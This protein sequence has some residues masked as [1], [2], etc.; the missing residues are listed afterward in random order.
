MV[1][2]V[3]GG[4]GFL[5]R[6]L[7]RRLA[8]EDII[9]RAYGRRL[10][11]S[12]GKVEFIYGELLDRSRLRGAL[13]GVDCVFHLA[14]STLPQTSNEDPQADVQG[15]VIA[16]I[17]LLEACVEA[18]VQTVVFPSSGGTVYGPAM[19]GLDLTE[20]HPTNPISSYGITKLAVEK[21]LALYRHLH[22]LDYRILRISN[23]YGE[24]Q[25]PDRPQGLIGVVLRRIA[26]GEPIQVWGDGQVV[27]DYV[28]AGD[29]V[30]CCV[31][32]A[33]ARLP[34]DGPRI[35]NVGSQQGRSVSEIL[36]TVFAVTGREPNVRHTPA[37][38]F[39]VA[40]S[41]LSSR[42]AH[43][44]LEWEARTTLDQG[45]ARTWQWVLRNAATEEGLSRDPA[46]D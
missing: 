7:L 19:G 5:G 8:R 42:L 12:P 28:Y 39:D 34:P 16:G 43:E 9:V 29:V 40:R 25:Q 35:F 4:S 17:G 13:E 11:T 20:A 33:L 37:R 2:L 23:A 31:R 14:W 1:V 30:D 22:G 32:A 24:G 41:V 44:V 45:V 27:R 15:N 21:Y 38:P 36:S 26:A 6:H 46:F 18:G 10:V 3:L